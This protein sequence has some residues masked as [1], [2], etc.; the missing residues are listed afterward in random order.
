MKFIKTEK[1]TNLKQ[2]KNLKNKD[3]DAEVKYS[4]CG[5]TLYVIKIGKGKDRKV[6]K[7]YD[8]VKAHKILKSL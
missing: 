6:R 4:A 5:A 2:Y 1:L 7:T 8:E 3:V